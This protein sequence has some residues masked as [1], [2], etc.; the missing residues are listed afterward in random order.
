MELILYVIITG[1][2]FVCVL[3]VISIHNIN[4]ALKQQG[5]FNKA[6]LEFNRYTN[7]SVRYVTDTLKEV[8]SRADRPN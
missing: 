7:N 1:L 6:Q 5:E 2:T 3:L 8:V 4:E